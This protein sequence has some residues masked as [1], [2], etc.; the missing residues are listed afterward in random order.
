MTA[1]FERTRTLALDHFSAGRYAKAAEAYERAAKLNPGH[2][3]VLAGL[4]AARA[5][6]GDLPGAQQAYQAAVRAEPRHSGYHA[7]LGRV[8][9][10]QGQRAAAATEYRLAVKLDPRNRAA[11]KA[12]AELSGRKQSRR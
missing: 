5:R 11:R 7:A 4:G 6:N 3:G 1:E 9:R 10:D 2:T 8:Y 12:L